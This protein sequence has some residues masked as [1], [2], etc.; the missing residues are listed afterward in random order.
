MRRWRNALAFTGLSAFVVATGSVTAY[1]HYFRRPGELATNF[2]PA[3][4]LAVVTLDT[5]P[6]PDQVALFKRIQD[7]IQSAGLSD[8]LDSA[9]RDMTGKA[10]QPGSGAPAEGSALLRDARPYLS[11]NFAL[12]LYEKPS[13]DMDGI[14]YVSVNDRAKIQEIA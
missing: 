4:A 1:R 5:N 9:L 6:A 7:A 8:Q 12:A 2:I 13:K 10:G 14:L 3:D 11:D